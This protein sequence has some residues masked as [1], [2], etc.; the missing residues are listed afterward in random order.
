MFVVATHL[1]LTFSTSLNFFYNAGVT[2]N[3]YSIKK[4]LPSTYLLGNKYSLV[5]FYQQKILTGVLFPRDINTP[6][7]NK[8]SLFT[9]YMQ[10]GPIKFKWVF[11]KNKIIFQFLTTD[12]VGYRFC[13]S[14][15][16]FEIFNYIIIKCSHNG[17]IWHFKR[18]ISIY[19]ISYFYGIEI[20]SIKYNKKRSF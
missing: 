13:C 15:N 5:T 16:T 3:K 10:T 19:Q 4:A 7:G 9:Y 8:Y 1:L 14:L 17:I 2:V 11:F 20:K 12:A 6:S 18:Q